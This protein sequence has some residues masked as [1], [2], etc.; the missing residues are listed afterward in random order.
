MVCFI[1][2]YFFVLRP[3]ASSE[4]RVCV[5]SVSVKRVLSVAE[6]SKRSV[7]DFRGGNKP[8]GPVTHTHRRGWRAAVMSNKNKNLWGEKHRNHYLHQ[9]WIFA[10]NIFICRKMQRDSLAVPEEIENEADWF[11]SANVIYKIGK[12]ACILS[13]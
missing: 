12:S 1:F 7:R 5:R 9:F 3:P 4:D 8:C 11:L 10:G 13:S 6:L 2:A